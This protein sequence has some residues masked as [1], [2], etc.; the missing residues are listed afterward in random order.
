MDRSVKITIVLGLIVILAALIPI[1][2][3]VTE[4]P[5]PINQEE[6]DPSKNQT[7][8]SGT[9]GSATPIN[10]DIPIVLKSNEYRPPSKEI[11]GKTIALLSKLKVKYKNEEFNLIIK[12]LSGNQ[13]RE[14]M[15]N[16]LAKLLIIAG[17]DKARFGGAHKLQT[18][19]DLP[20]FIVSCNPGNN[21]FGKDL[22]N[23]LLPYIKTSFAVSPDESIDT[24]TVQITI[25]GEPTFLV[26]G[27]VFLSKQ[28]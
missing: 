28:Q 3:K 20:P 18:K 21:E 10:K 2:S 19:K 7:A 1:L 12:F 17:F 25:C 27:S 5:A 22:C 8:A 6:N 26:N 24:R 15:A 13:N 14:R 4:Q 9:S 11:R 16:T 23:S